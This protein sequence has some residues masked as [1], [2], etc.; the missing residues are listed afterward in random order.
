LVLVVNNIV[1]KGE[2]FVGLGYNEAVKIRTKAR[3]LIP[4]FGYFIDSIS[5]CKVDKHKEDGGVFI[6]RNI[7]G[8]AYF[9]FILLRD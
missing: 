5:C 9:R 3:W 2:S 7:V 6:G 8:I 1:C 4:L